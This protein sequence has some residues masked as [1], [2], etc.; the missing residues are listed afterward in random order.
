[1]GFGFPLFYIFLKYCII[2]LIVSIA[3]YNAIVLYWAV[4]NSD[5]LCKATPNGC[6]SFMVSFSQIS[7]VVSNAEIVVRIFSFII[8]LSMLLYIR[9]LITKTSSYYDERSCS[10]SNYSIIVKNL[11]EAKGTRRNLINFLENYF[12]KPYKIYQ[13]TLLP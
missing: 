3:S 5:V 13:I 8:Q 2:L 6:S 11:P 1:L 4:T 9:D 7:G 10:L 12:E